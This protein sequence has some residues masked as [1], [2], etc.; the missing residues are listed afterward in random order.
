MKEKKKINKKPILII[1]FF[2][3]DFIKLKIINYFFFFFQNKKKLIQKIKKK[4]NDITL[5]RANIKIS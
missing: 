5:S 3:F 2:P 4:K 1:I